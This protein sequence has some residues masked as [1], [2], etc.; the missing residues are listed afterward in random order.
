MQ[1]NWAEQIMI[2]QIEAV[3][4]VL[5]LAPKNGRYQQQDAP[6]F[7]RWTASSTPS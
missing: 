6:L 1:P 7:V 3:S 5:G 2:D 4:K